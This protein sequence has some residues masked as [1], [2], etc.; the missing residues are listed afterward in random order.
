[1]VKSKKTLR[2][3]EVTIV[4]RFNVISKNLVRIQLMSRPPLLIWKQ[5]S[6]DFIMWTCLNPPRKTHGIT[7]L[8]EIGIVGVVE[9]AGVDVTTGAGAET[10]K[11]GVVHAMIPTCK[12]TV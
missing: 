5:G 8:E 3:I 4:P 2:Q 1:M 12:A 6:R 7:G 10:G 9:T 11:T